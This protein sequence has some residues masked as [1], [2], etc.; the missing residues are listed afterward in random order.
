MATSAQVAYVNGA[1]TTN[2]VGAR[3]ADLLWFDYV[4]ESHQTIRFFVLPMES[5]ML[6]HRPWPIPYVEWVVHLVECERKR[7]DT[8][9]WVV[10]DREIDILVEPDLQTYR[11]I[12]LEELG[13]AVAC[14]S[15]DTVQASAILT[16][17]Q[18]FLDRYLHGG[19]HFPPAVI[20]ASMCAPRE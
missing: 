3:D 18:V 14:G 5:V 1:Q 9:S 7:Q 10:T 4:N 11:I 6:A 16:A 17:T 15:I 12:D 8:E 19:G 2:W 20:T 13:G